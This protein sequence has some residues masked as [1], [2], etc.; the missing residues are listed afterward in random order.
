MLTNLKTIFPRSFGGFNS[1]EKNGFDS[2]VVR[3]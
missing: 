2:E 3:F 1:F